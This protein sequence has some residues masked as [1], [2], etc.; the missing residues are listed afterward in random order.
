LLAHKNATE[1]A[2]V[3]SADEMQI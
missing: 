3:Y 2:S 1:V